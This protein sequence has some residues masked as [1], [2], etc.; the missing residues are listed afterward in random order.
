MIYKREHI[1]Y[2]IATIILVVS[3]LIPSVIKIAHIFEHHTH[4]VCKNNQT[5]HIHKVDLNCDF[6]KFNLNK[7]LFFSF[8]KF[9]ETQEYISL[10][11]S[12]VYYTSYNNYLCLTKFLRGPPWFV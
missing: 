6:Q 5:T 2:K 12:L 8:Y 3:L 10:N 7:T 4:I 11:Q 1:S 9:N